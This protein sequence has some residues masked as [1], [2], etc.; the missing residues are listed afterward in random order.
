MRGLIIPRA[1]VITAL[2]FP[3]NRKVALVLAIAAMWLLGGL[4]IYVLNASDHWF[5]IGLDRNDFYA[6]AQIGLY[7]F[8][9]AGAQLP[10]LWTA[11]FLIG[12]SD[13]QHPV[14]VACFA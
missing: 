13:F 2:T 8:V 12:R 4:G 10:A 6:V 5:F 11:A 3:L 9:C 14:R 7:Y 1:S